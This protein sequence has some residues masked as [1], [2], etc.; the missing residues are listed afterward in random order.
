MANFVDGA[1]QGIAQ[2]GNRCTFFCPALP[3]RRL[4]YISLDMLLFSSKTDCMRA[5]SP[6]S[7]T[8]SHINLSNGNRSGLT[9]F[10]LL[11]L[12]FLFVW[13]FYHF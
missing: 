9:Q 2:A 1:L 12:G 6:I 5:S 11:L 4:L 13:G 3:V 8:Q 7:V 10:I